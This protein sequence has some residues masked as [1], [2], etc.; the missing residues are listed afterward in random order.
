MNRSKSRFVFLIILWISVSS[1]LQ[2]QT[3]VLLRVVRAEQSD[4]LGCNFVEE[5]I[6]IVYLEIINNRVKLWDS[7]AKEVQI[8][9]AT[10][11]EIERA[12]ATSFQNQE[13]VFIYEYWSKDGK[14][15]KSVTQGF[16]FNTKSNT[17]EDVS[18]GYIDYKDLQD[19]FLG[20]RVNSNANGNFSASISNYINRKEY[21]YNILQ[22]NG[23]VVN[24]VNES[25]QIQNSYIGAS[26]F[27]PTYFSTIEIPQK[28]VTYFIDNTN[29]SDDKKF[30]AGKQF[31][32]TI[33][34]YL[35][36]NEE[37]FYNLGGDAIVGHLQQKKWSITRIVV[38]EIWKKIDEVVKYDPVSLLIFVNDSSLAEIPLRDM[39]KMD[40]QQDNKSWIQLL[41]EKNFQIVITKINAQDIARKHSYLF[42]KAMQSSPWNKLMDYV[43]E[44]I[45]Y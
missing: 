35:A 10:L 29:L 9:A 42:Y 22:F 20:A 19:A 5:L 45:K 33:E 16:T 1:F 24:G 8:N 34:T 11:K 7:P 40:I 41:K 38:K 39:I 44:N 36:N 30:L 15:I 25:Q 23:K 26:K 43:T 18:Y 4:S 3:P 21:A 28:M 17:G 37:V 12:S 32:K 6:R 31:T 2:A 27:N 13:I 14:A